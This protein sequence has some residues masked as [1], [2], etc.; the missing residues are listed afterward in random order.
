MI[1]KTPKPL[2][3]LAGELIVPYDR[4]MRL[5]PKMRHREKRLLEEL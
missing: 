4:N 5:H 2:Y 3:K 1:S